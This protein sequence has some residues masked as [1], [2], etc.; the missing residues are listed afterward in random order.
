MDLIVTHAKCPDG[1]AAAFIAKKRYPEAEI[2]A[3]DHGEP[4][5]FDTVRGKDVLVTDFSWP[6]REDNIK[7]H[8]IAKSFHIYDHHKSALERIGDLPFVTFDMKRSGASLTWDYLFG[9]DSGYRTSQRLIGWLPRPWYVDFVEDRDLWNWALPFSKEI[10]AY[11]M[12]L[13]FTIGA[14][15]HLDDINPSEAVQRGAAV[16]SHINRYVQE[17]T[18][19]AQRGFIEIADHKFL[20]TEVVNCPYMNCSEVGNVLAQRADVGLTWFERADGMIAFSLRSVGDIDVSEIAKKY[21]GGGHQHAAGF[22]L[23]IGEGREL[24]D[25]ILGR[26]DYNG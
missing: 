16:V 18:D 24:L 7:L 6:V 11:I 19:E 22:R 15:E 2:L 8:S 17:A 25:T 21:L 9:E 23:P 5:P 14:W 1:W 3:L 26:N 4:V 10:N 12:T 13:P 20:T